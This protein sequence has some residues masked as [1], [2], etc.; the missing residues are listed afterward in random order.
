M[1]IRAVHEHR[2]NQVSKYLGHQTRKSA[3]LFQRKHMQEHASS[4]F[5]P[6]LFKNPTHIKTPNITEPISFLR[7]LV[8]GYL[9]MASEFREAC[10]LAHW[11]TINRTLNRLQTSHRS[12]RYEC[13]LLPILR[14]LQGGGRLLVQRL[15]EE[16]SGAAHGQLNSA[17]KKNAIPISGQAEAKGESS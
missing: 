5:G 12:L 1:D 17:Q 9:D 8:Q 14:S 2:I 3:V 10:P 13:H 7:C 11:R 6:E 15:Q 4:Q 16:S